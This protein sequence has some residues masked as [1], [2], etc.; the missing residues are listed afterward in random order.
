[1]EWRLNRGEPIS[2]SNQKILDDLWLIVRSHDDNVTASSNVSRTRQL[3]DKAQEA[4]N[5]RYVPGH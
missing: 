4:R 2:A 1:M 3:T 5:S